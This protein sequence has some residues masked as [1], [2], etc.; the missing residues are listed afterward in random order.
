MRKKKNNGC[1]RITCAKLSDRAVDWPETLEI[2]IGKLI[3]ALP[4][5]RRSKQVEKPCF[6]SVISSLL[7]SS[8][9]AVG[10]QKEPSGPA[11]GDSTL[12]IDSVKGF[13]SCQ[14]GHNHGART[15]QQGKGEQGR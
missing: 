9:I 1:R 13:Q 15:D 12:A 14:E 6:Q 11:P 3:D 5:L 7:L 4:H 10:L 8:H 2:S